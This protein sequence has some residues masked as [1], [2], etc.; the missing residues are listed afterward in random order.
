MFYER[1]IVNGVAMVLFSADNV[2]N[3]KF[4]ISGPHERQK[5]K[6]KDVN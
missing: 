1:T 5:L 3:H 2:R 6:R 4:K